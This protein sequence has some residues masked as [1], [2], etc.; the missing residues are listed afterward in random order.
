MAPAGRAGFTFHAVVMDEPLGM[1]RAVLE[2]GVRARGLLLAQTDAARRLALFGLVAE[3][4]DTQAGLNE[5]KG[6]SPG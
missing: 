6:D 3:S 5:S 1:I 4:Q 2:G